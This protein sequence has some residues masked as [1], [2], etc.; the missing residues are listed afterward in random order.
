MLCVGNCVIVVVVIVVVVVVV[1]RYLMKLTVCW[2]W[3]L[4]HR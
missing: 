2:T 3:V 1:I 4:N